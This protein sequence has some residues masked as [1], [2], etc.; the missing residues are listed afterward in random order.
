MASSFEV[1][2]KL[3][4]AKNLKN[5][6][7]RNGPNRPYAVV[8]V[9]PT[10]KRSTNVDES[11]DTQPK[12]D[13]KLLIPLPPSASIN[14]SVLFIDV[15]HS[16][17]NDKPLI[18][19]STRLPLDKVE[20]EDGSRG[21]RT[22]ELRRPS[23]RPQGTI[24]IKVIVKNTGYCAPYGVPPPYGAPYG[25]PPS[26]YGNSYGTGVSVTYGNPYNVAPPPLGYPVV[27]P[28]YGYN[29]STQHGLGSGPS[30]NVTVGGTAAPEKNNQSYGYGQGGQQSGPTVNVTVG[31]VAPEKNNAPQSFGYGQSGPQ[32][33]GYGQSGSTVNVIVG[34]EVQQEKK[35]S[36]FG[37]GTGLVMGA[38]VGGIGALAL[39]KGIDAIEDKIAD[40]VVEKQEIDDYYEEYYNEY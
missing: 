3:H 26:P 20:T 27:A 12:W 7:W 8:W 16:E 33:S 21:S 10:Q 24:D 30:V 36:K 23:G 17:P 11:G 2:V 5:V 6:N 32:G 38:V 4:S 35:S 22:L 9:D 14:N 1:E 25:A 37:L 31:G 18:I 13:E 34:K 39:E 40:R 15:L 28:T 19:G 29:Q